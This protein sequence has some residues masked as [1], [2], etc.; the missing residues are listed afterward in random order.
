AFGPA[1]PHLVIVG[2]LLVGGFFR[3]LQFTSLNGMAYADI[4]P[5]R[6]S[7]ASTLSSMAQQLVQSIGIGLAATLLTVSMQA[8]G[9]T[10]LTAAVIA[11][12]F[13]VIGA[14]TFV[15]LAFYLRLPRDAGDEMNGR[16]LRT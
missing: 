15:S 4:D 13:L 7:R 12:I 1:T 11:P 8:Q 3:S 10:T 6:M 14:V 5:E 16:T 2:V 9:Q